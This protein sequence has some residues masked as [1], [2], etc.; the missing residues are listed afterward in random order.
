LEFTTWMASAI[1]IGGRLRVDLLRSSG[2][3]V[4]GPPS[5]LN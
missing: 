4:A 1:G 2:K 3:M 5:V